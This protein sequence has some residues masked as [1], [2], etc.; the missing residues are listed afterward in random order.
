MF[1]R[2]CILQRSLAAT[3]PRY[4]YKT[5]TAKKQRHKGPCCECMG[6]IP[7]LSYM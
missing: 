7:T 5:M 1:R 4:I 2:F 6:T 3:V